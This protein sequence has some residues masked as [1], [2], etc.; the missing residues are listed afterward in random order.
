MSFEN[1]LENA[2]SLKTIKVL[3]RKRGCEIGEEGEDKEHY[4]LFTTKKGRSGKVV[5]SSVEKE[6]KPYVMTI[7]SELITEPKHLI[8]I[9]RNITKPVLTAYRNHFKSFFKLELMDIAFLQKSIFISP[10]V[11]KY[12]LLTIDEKK[13]IIKTYGGKPKEQMLMKED[14]PVAI[15]LNLTKGQMV[16]VI[17]YYDHSLQKINK[18]RPP[19]IWYRYII[20]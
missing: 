15:S 14:D 20:E 10:L 5:W 1:S 3:L 9:Y 12:E 17:S 6:G 11:P 7:F 19:T 4:L 2:R 8:F 16:R 13:K 18:E